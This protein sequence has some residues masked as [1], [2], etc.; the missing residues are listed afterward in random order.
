MNGTDSFGGCQIMKKAILT[1]Y[2]DQLRDAFWWELRAR[3]TPQSALEERV[4]GKTVLITGASSG[5]GEALARRLAS[6]NARLL[7]V[8]RRA[9]KLETLASELRITGAS[10]GVYPADLTQASDCERLCQQLLS[11]EGN[12]DI[13]VN[14]AGHSIR[15]S[16]K[17][18]L[19]RFH[20]FERTMQ[21]NYFAPVRL[22]LQLL[23]AMRKRGNGH[24]INVS[25]LG[26]Q[27]S[28]P[29]F[30]AYLASKGALEHWTRIAAIEFLH[31]GISFSLANF[32]LVRTPM[33]A[34]TR[35]YRK[36]PAMPPDTAAD[37]IC[38]LII[39]RQKRKV[40]AGGLFA[41]TASTLFP[42]TSLAAINLIYQLTVESSQ[43]QPGEVHRLQTPRH[44]S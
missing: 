27:T 20:D 35:L 19:L 3:V 32:P 23:P 17:H 39:T 16:I 2:F 41:A 34:P 11:A 5:I 26:I 14:N 28:P 43:R 44:H 4:A 25:T 37:W 6:T 18:S 40:S 10:V 15:R 7:L 29:R 31:E 9:E 22:S 8:A 12:V 42:R 1:P 38:D 33:I 13:L 30:A 36:L 24:V 21:L